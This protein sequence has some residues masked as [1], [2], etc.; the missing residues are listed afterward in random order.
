ME[1]LESLQTSGLGVWVRTSLVGY[2]T[3]IASHAIG[4]AVMVGLSVAFALR[5]LGCF[6]EIPYPALNRFLV[7]AWIG[8]AINFLSGSGLFAAQATTYIKDGTFLLK[9]AFV[10]AGMSAVAIN[11]TQVKRHAAGWGD[12]AASLGTRVVACLTIFC[13]VAATV[14]GRLIAYL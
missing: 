3:M 6:R 13:W 7:I 2:P 8:F 11:Q 14:T 10:V 5:V 1:F 9:M 12:A 4:M